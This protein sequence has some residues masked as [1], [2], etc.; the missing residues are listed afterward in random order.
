MLTTASACARVRLCI[1]SY[2]RPCVHHRHACTRAH[3]HTHMH[4]TYMFAYVHVHIYTH[5]CTHVSNTGTTAVAEGAAQDL[6]PLSAQLDPLSAKQPAGPEICQTRAAQSPCP[7]TDTTITDATA[8]DEA[9]TASASATA[10]SARSQPDVDSDTALR[11]FHNKQATRTPQNPAPPTPSPLHPQPCSLDPKRR[12]SPRGLP[13]NVAL[14]RS[15]N[16]QPTRVSAC[17]ACGV[18]IHGGARADA[19]LGSAGGTIAAGMCAGWY[20]DKDCVLKTTAL[21]HMYCRPAAAVE[22][23][24]CNCL[25]RAGVWAS[26]DYAI[27]ACRH[28][29]ACACTVC[30]AYIHMYEHEID[31]NIHACIHR[32]TDTCSHR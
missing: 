28:A 1:S 24:C 32:S 7:D 3:M 25:R 20:D 29:N 17:A 13:P 11:R 23:R 4:R 8:T 12:S 21:V 18:V 15:S 26:S 5:T 16:T 14:R 31:A 30:H 2:V 10:Q 22:H 9:A 6:D 19:L 27:L